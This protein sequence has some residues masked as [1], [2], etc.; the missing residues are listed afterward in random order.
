[1]LKFH[2]KGISN[3]SEV[4]EFDAADV[5][6]GIINKEDESKTRPG[7]LDWGGEGP[8]NYLIKGRKT[9]KVVKDLGINNKYPAF[10][11]PFLVGLGD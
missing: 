10:F 2:P 1:M 11:R 5:W 9:I 8:T 7:D 4:Q 6:G 3:R